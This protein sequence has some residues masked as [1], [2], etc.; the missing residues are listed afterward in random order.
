MKPDQSKQKLPCR[1]ACALNI[2]AYNAARDTTAGPS[3]RS[4]Y[5]VIIGGSASYAALLLVGLV[6][7]LTTW[8][9]SAMS[10]SSST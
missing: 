3:A 10:S 6:E 7:I 4:T 8:T 9:S 5:D 2:A 1:S